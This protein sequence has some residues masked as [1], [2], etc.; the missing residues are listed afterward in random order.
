VAVNYRF[1]TCTPAD[2]FA[3]LANGWLYPSW[4]VGA[5]RMRSVDD[6]WPAPGSALHHSVGVWPLVLNDTTSVLEWDPP[7]HALLRARGWPLGE[8]SVAVDVQQ[9]KNGCLI[10]IREVGTAGPARLIP[11]VITDPALRVR[12]VETLKRLSYLAEGRA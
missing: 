4:V 5:T 6:T 1:V 3:V 10:R 2:V 12:N 7:R 11:R 9:R 8:A